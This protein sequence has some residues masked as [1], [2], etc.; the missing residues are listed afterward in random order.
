MVDGF[1]NESV[2]GTLNLLRVTGVVRLTP[3]EEEEEEFCG[4]GELST[5]E[6]KEKHAAAMER[7][8]AK[9]VQRDE[10]SEAIASSFDAWPAQ[11]V[12]HD[13]IHTAYAQGDKFAA[14]LPDGTYTAGHG[15]SWNLRDEQTWDAHSA[16]ISAA[17]GMDAENFP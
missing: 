6:V 14:Q 7:Y 4:W 11:E 16:R 8:H 15:F 13:K 9:R 10:A 12:R 3:D 17:L 5:E 2:Y 1:C